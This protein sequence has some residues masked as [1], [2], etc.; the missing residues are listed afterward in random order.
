M[1]HRRRAAIAT[2]LGTTTNTFVVSLQAVIL[3]PLYLHF[4]GSR[5]YGSWLAS[6]EMLVWM[7][8]LDLGLPNVLIQRIGAADGAGDDRTSGEYFATGALF[9]LLLSVA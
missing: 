7:Q 6:G 5:L 3:A 8:T 1:T 4:V 2:L 9:L